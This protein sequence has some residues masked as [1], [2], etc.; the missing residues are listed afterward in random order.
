MGGWC[1]GQIVDIS[2]REEVYKAAAEI[3]NNFGDVSGTNSFWQQIDLEVL[4]CDRDFAME[5]E[6]DDKCRLLSALQRHLLSGKHCSAHELIAECR[7]ERFSQWSR[8]WPS[9]AALEI[10]KKET[11]V[12]STCCRQ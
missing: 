2:K 10:W 11:L 9:R 1:R 6:A 4:A 12:T 3:K 8:Q 7:K 5:S